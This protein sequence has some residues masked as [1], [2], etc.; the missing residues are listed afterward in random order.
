MRLGSKVK[1]VH[2]RHPY[3]TAFLPRSNTCPIRRNY[4][5]LFS[6]DLPPLSPFPFSGRFLVPLPF[7]YSPCRLLISPAVGTSKGLRSFARNNLL[8]APS[9]ERSAH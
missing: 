8:S 3:L 6:A 7:R 9:M 1:I 5:F 4:S 2:G